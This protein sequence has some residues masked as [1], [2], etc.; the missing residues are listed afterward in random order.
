MPNA[1]ISSVAI[2]FV[3]INKNLGSMTLLVLRSGNV[4]VGEDGNFFYLV[5]TE[6]PINSSGALNRMM[7][8]RVTDTSK[9]ERGTI[10]ASVEYKNA[11]LTG[12]E[13]VNRLL[14]E[15]G[16]IFPVPNKLL[17]FPMV[18]II[19]SSA[20]RDS[21]IAEDVVVLTVPVVSV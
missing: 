11:V 20:P 12:Y 8:Y 13:V 3:P 1:F 4:L 2:S 6:C 9:C 16:L 21:D 18:I 17:T 15:V 19:M 14:R 10:L 7:R 5:G